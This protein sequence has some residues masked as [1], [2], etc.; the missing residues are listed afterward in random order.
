MTGLHAPQSSANLRPCL[1]VAYQP[2]DDS[3]IRV[4]L[5]APATHPPRV[6]GSVP[7]PSLSMCGGGAG[8]SSVVRP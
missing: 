6:R 5:T 2:A 4:S 1:S 7:A 3:A 8:F